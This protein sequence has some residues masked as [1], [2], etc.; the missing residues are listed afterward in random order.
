MQVIAEQSAAT[1]TPTQN[2]RTNGTATATDASG[3]FEDLTPTQTPDSTATAAG[4]SNESSPFPDIASDVELPAL[5][6]GEGPLGVL[7]PFEGPVRIVSVIALVGFVG[8]LYSVFGSRN[9]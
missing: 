5:A 3:T 9:L 1:A 4:D 6:W 7:P 2:G 8:L